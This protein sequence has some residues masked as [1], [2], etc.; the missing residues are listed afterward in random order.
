MRPPSVGHGEDAVGLHRHAGEPLAHHRDLGDRVGAFERVGSSPSGNSVPK[1][2]FEP[3]S[4]NSSGASGASAVGRGDDRGQRV[5]VDDHRLGGVDGLRL[6]SRRRPRRRC[7]RRSA[8]C[9]WRRSAGSASG[10]I[11][12][13]PCN[14]GSPRSSPPAW[15]TATT[16]GIDAASLTSTDATLAWATVERTNATCSM[17]GST[18]SSTYLPVAGQQRRILQPANRVA[19]DRT[20]CGHVTY[21]PMRA[22][23]HVTQVR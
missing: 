11:I 2:T 19:E 7:R 4:G 23:G 9:R 6:R 8:P 16:P 3:C 20:R 17:P 18:R 10:G 21:P 22:S 13:K 12:A 15:Y 5:V 14:A 1:Q